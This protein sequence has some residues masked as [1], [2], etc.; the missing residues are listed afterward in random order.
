MNVPF[1]SRG[2]KAAMKL[3]IAGVWGWETTLQQRF[4]A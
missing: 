3:F 1:A 2:N 4:A